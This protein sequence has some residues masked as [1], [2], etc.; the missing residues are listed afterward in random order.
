VV[1][2]LGDFSG[3]YPWQWTPAEGEAFIAQLRSGARPAAMSTARSYETTIR[4]F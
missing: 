2:R 1:R 3:L 4:L